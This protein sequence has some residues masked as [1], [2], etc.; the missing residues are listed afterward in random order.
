[1]ELNFGASAPYTVGVEEEF[2]L[3]G[4]SSFALVPAIEDVLA[5][6]DAAGLFAGS[7]TS[8]LFASCLEARSPVCGTVAEL[9]SELTALR[10]RVRGLVERCEV[11]L[12]AAG[13]HPFSDATAQPIT[14]GERYRR[15]EEE[16]GWAARMQAIYGLHVHVAVP[17]EEHAIRAVNALSRHVPLFVALSANSPFWRGVDTRLTS[18][19]AKIFGLVPRSGL[20]PHFRSWGDF[21]CYVDTLV[22]AASIPDYTWCWWDARPHPRLGTVELRALDAQTDASWTASLAALAQCLVAA[23]DVYPPED[24]LLTEENKWRAI[25]YG[26]NARLHDFSTGQSVTARDAIRG[27]IKALGDVSQDLGCEAELAGVLGILKGGSGAEKQRAVFGERGSPEDVV[28]Y[29]VAS[30]A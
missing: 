15:V 5:A 28:A 4:P 3:V 25:R 22:G 13:T 10:R 18:A 9:A 2:Q 16:M 14:A 1:M 19:R 7:I 27:L 12:A 11:R 29:L 23:A 24:P 8:E 30:T 26:L 17:D 20:P 21:E 6:R